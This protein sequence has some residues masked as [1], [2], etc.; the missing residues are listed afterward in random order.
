MPAGKFPSTDYMQWS[1][2]IKLKLSVW[3]DKPCSFK[4]KNAVI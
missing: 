1:V 2:P 4:E 3:V